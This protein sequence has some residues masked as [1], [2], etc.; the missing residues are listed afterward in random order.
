MKLVLHQL[1]FPLPG[2]FSINNNTNSLADNIYAAI[3]NINTHIN[4]ADS[5]VDIIREHIYNLHSRI[6]NINTRINNADSPVGI[7]HEHIYILHSPIYNINAFKNIFYTRVNNIYVHVKNIYVDYFGSN[8]H[9]FN[10]NKSPFNALFNTKKHLFLIKTTH[11][12]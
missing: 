5:P 1:P 6:D 4:N 3:H 2:E 9:Y 12:N 8:N 7:I 11:F 10:K